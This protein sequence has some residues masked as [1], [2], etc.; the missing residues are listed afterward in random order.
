MLLAYVSVAVLTVLVIY[1][2]SRRED[3]RHGEVLSGG[4]REL[5]PLLVRLPVALLAAGFLAA[6]IPERWMLMLLGD[7]SG[8]V[9]ILLASLLGAVLPGG[10]IVTFPL[11]MA[12]A[13]AGVGTPQLVALLTAWSVLALHRVMAFEIPMIGWAFVWRRLAVSLVLAPLAGLLA[14]WF[15]SVGR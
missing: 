8:I 9:G 11:A 1:V 3:V 7:A 4:W 10:P 12:L 2:A 13:S 6:L 14:A 5:R 15:L